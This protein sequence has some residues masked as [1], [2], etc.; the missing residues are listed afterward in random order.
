MFDF[1]SFIFFPRL[2]YASNASTLTA[3]SNTI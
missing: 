3:S 1:I 2:L